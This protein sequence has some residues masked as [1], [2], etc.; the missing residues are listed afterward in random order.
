ML[1]IGFSE[2]LFSKQTYFSSSLSFW[3]LKFLLYF[4]GSFGI[5]N[6]FCNY[7]NATLLAFLQ[8]F[9]WW[10]SFR[11]FIHLI[12]KVMSL[13]LFIIIELV[14]F[15]FRSRIWAFLWRRCDDAFSG[16]YF[17]NSFILLFPGSTLNLKFTFLS[18]SFL[19]SFVSFI[20][21][22]T[23]SFYIIYYNFKYLVT[24]RNNVWKALI[25]HHA[26]ESSAFTHNAG[27]TREIT[28]N[29]ELIR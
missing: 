29:Y 4:N 11:C 21:S 12:H 6:S 8:S 25:G 23:Y 18:L 22:F 13:F 10:F 15:F 5:L 3:A 9:C 28:Q 26:I 14:V 24:C 19:V 20:S 27:N 17:L 2:V 7:I 1:K 16:F